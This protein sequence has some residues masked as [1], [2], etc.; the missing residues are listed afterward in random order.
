MDISSGFG[1]MT[2]NVGANVSEFSF[3]LAVPSQPNRNLDNSL[4]SLEC[5]LIS[6]SN[7]CDLSESSRG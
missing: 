7:I 1:L 3:N 6:Y 2:L 5:I 4:N